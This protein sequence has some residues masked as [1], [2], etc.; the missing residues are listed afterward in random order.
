MICDKGH[1]IREEVK[2]LSIKV[3]GLNNAANIRQIGELSPDFMGFIFWEQSKR[4]ACRLSPMIPRELPKS[5]KKVGVFV[6]EEIDKVLKTAEI[7]DLQKVQLHGDETPEY[8]DRLKSYGLQ[9][10]KALGVATEEDVAK[11]GRYDGSVSMMVFDTKSSQRGGTGKS[12]DRTILNSYE[13]ETPFLLSGGI[14]PEDAEQILAMSLT[15]MA[16]VDI[17]SRFETS[18]GMKDVAMVD[19]FIKRLRNFDK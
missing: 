16:G 1:I 6:N 17:N 11:A 4:N 12:Y 9:V 7:Y 14:G 10:I 19:N 18:P 3:C 2:P 13:G 5:I 8:C 15:R